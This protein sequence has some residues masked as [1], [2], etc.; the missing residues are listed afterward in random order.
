MTS[1]GTP[2]PDFPGD[3]RMKGFKTRASVE[4]LWGWIAGSISRADGFVV[5]PAQLEGFA[6]GAVVDVWCYDELGL[7]P[8]NPL[9]A[10]RP[11]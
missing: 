1:T 2:G 7:E 8:R 11:V 5:V 9:E 6:A 3:P 4:E 10:G